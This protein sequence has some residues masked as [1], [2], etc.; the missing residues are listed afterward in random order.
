MWRHL[1]NVFL[2]I[3]Y[4]RVAGFQCCQEEVNELA[5]HPKGEYLA[6][7]DDSG[8]VRVYNTRT[9]MVDKTLR[10][11]HTVGANTHPANRSTPYGFD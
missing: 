9:R 10:N 1:L 7:A 3:V 2:V 8:R 5:M 6:A 4:C 11:A